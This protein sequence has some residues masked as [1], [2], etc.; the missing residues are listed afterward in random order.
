[1]IMPWIDKDGCIGCGICVE[2]CPVNTIY[3]EDGKAQIN[4]EN[5]IHCGICHDVCPNK[6]VKHD[7]EKI[8]DEV[9]ANIAR[10][11][12]Y[13]DACARYLGDAGEKQN[14]LNRMIKHF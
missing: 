12:E 11:K 14:C 2:E 9:E 13:M 6:V 10:T 1:D 5:C 7:M 3:M 8:P 4:M